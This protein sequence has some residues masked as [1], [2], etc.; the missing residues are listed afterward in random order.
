M[1]GAFDRM[2]NQ[3][4]FAERAYQSALAALETARVEAG[5]QQVYLATIVSPNLPQEPGFPRP[6]RGTASAFGIAMAIWA[7]LI[8]AASAVR[9]HL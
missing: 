2:E 8:L 6:W 4:V 7:I 3:R 1:L 9:Q 5:R